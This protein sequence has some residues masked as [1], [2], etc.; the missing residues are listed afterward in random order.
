M[1]DEKIIVSFGS[2]FA[3]SAETEN[4][5]SKLPTKA[6]EIARQITR[7]NLD[8][9]EDAAGTIIDLQ[10]K[11]DNL[12]KETAKRFLALVQSYDMDK[13]DNTP[14][15]SW[16]EFAKVAWDK[17]P[18]WVTQNRRVA[19]EILNS[20]DKTAIEISKTFNFSQLAEL[21]PL[22]KNGI[23]PHIAEG[24]E[25]G[26]LSP[27][28]PATGNNPDNP[29]IRMWVKGF[30]NDGV[31]KIVLY[32]VFFA[33]SGKRLDAVNIDNYIPAIDDENS[34]VIRFNP[35][36]KDMETNI[37]WKGKVVIDKP[38]MKAAVVLYHKHKAKEEKV[39]HLDDTDRLAVSIR[40]MPE[41]FRAD[42]VHSYKGNDKYDYGKLC[43]LV[44]VEQ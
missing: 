16:G 43:H 13:G 30:V 29:S 26:E 15:K 35:N 5:I 34:V 12:A 1:K 28:M 20:K 36:T 21:L 19:A 40:E 22:T 6:Q 2:A 42:I 8:A 31:S 37:D 38:T 14:F 17:S 24:L 10:N 33:E 4:A 7:E 39:L 11:S 23:S 32:D 9:R 25:S 3:M 27:A 44:G 41:Q 18:S